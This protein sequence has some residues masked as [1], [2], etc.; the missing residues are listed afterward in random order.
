MDNNFQSPEQLQ[1]LKIDK[2]FSQTELTIK[3]DNI[4]SYI[5]EQWDKAKTAKINIEQEMIR[6]RDQ[7]LGKYSNNKLSAIKNY[8]PG[9]S[10]TF[11]PMTSI[12]CKAAQAAINEVLSPNFGNSWGLNPT[13]IPELDP[14]EEAEITQ[15]LL[16]KAM[17]NAQAINGDP[18]IIIPQMMAIA[19]EEIDNALKTH[20]EGLIEHVTS[21]IE[22]KFVQGNYSNAINEFVYDLVTYPLGCIK[23]S[24]IM[25]HSY[26]RELQP[27]GTYISKVSPIATDY[28]QRIS[29]F[30]IY[31]APDSTGVNDGDLIYKNSITAKDLNALIRVE[32]FNEKE[33]RAVLKEYREGGLVQL[34]A[35]N[36]VD[37]E[38]IKSISTHTSNLS[39]KIDVIEFYGNVQGKL[40]IEWGLTTIDG[41]P[42]D[43]DLEYDICAYLIGNHVIKAYLNEDPLGEKP[44]VTCSWENIPGSFYGRG[45]PETMADL[46]ASLNGTQ[47]N[48]ENNIAYSSLPITEVNIDRLDKNEPTLNQLLP[49]SVIQSTDDMNTNTAA[50]R[51]YQPETRTNE[52][53]NAYMLWLRMIDETCGIPS[54]AHGNTDVG[55]SNTASA[56]AMFTNASNKIIKSVIKGID[57]KIIAPL[58]QKAYFSIVAED[59]S[60]LIPDMQIVA[61]GSNILEEKSQLV[62]RNIE[63]LNMTSNPV[64]MQIL[65][66]EGRKKLLGN[67]FKVMGHDFNELFKGSDTMPMEGIENGQPNPNQVGLPSQQPKPMSLDAAG[68]PVSGTDTRQFGG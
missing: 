9:G 64:D 61:K 37:A 49:N 30:D 31:P 66:I 48:I 26:K 42:I 4:A 1:Q 57:D 22:D 65:G 55:G 34:T 50:I 21:M 41:N 10:E 63:L 62:Q 7:R 12:K 29:P 46:Q 60:N 52:L 43:E 24:T 44:F 40:L 13:P 39:H 2:E 53:Q 18:Q 67:V 51:Y 54:F 17:M 23:T 56:L 59:T 27:D 47:R 6:N 38:Q 33:I 16:A 32:G 19:K 5:Q 36:S 28:W 35:I 68:N 20:T 25:K 45:L 15:Q 58:V 14:K 8:I 3:V 11:V